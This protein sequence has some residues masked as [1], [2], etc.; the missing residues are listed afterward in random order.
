MFFKRHPK[1]EPEGMDGTVRRG[2]KMR[3]VLSLKSRAFPRHREDQREDTSCSEGHH[4][5]QRG[6]GQ[7]LEERGLLSEAR[8]QKPGLKM[9]VHPR[10]RVR[11]GVS[12]EG[13]L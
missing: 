3:R 8:R 9:T 5:T 1:G 11:G 2:K 12:R 6:Q 10:E 4:H 13:Q 7:Q